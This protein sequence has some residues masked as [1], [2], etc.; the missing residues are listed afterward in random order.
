MSSRIKRVL[1]A[2]INP[3][4]SLG[5]LRL[6]SREDIRKVMLIR[7]L[8]DNLGLNLAGVEFVLNLVDNLIGMKQFL[9]EA[10]EGNSLHPVIGRAMTQL[11]RN[12][13]LPLEE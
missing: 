2:F 6:Y 11:F 8:M 13:N 1:V 5:M 7:H 12:L 9:E 10:A 3:G 4:R